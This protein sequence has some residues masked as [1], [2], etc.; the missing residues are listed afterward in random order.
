PYDRLVLAPGIDI[1]FDSVP[2][3]SEEISKKL[4]HAWQAGAQTQLL[5]R[6]LNALSD[7]A[8]IVMI[9]PPN[10]YRCP[11]GPYERVSVMAHVLRPRATR[12]RASSSS[13]RRKTSPSRACS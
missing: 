12:N 4:P 11:P 8:T 3:Y 13:T 2:G 7:G 9:A 10:P 1:K 6:Q 5:K